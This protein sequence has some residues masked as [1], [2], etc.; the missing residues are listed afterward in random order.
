MLRLRARSCFKF[1]RQCRAQTEPGRVQVVPCS[2]AHGSSCQ[3]V[4]AAIEFCG[5]SAGNLASIATI[6]CH[7]PKHFGVQCAYESGCRSVRNAVQD[8]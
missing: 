7:E 1:G 4:A 8:D 3:R 2:V 6:V 5:G